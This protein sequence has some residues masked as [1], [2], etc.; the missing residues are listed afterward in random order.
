MEVLA[1]PIARIY[2]LSLS[3][4][5]FPDIFRHAIIHPVFKAGGKSPRDPGSYRPI[6]IL[7]SLSKIL[8]IVVRNT[9]LEWLDTINF[10]PKSQF[11]FL[12]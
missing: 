2:N 7:S 11:G 4:G 9:L 5:V 8:E 1:G 12:P 3:T 6:S 10:I